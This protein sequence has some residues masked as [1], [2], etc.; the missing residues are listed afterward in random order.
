[1]QIQTDAA[2]AMPLVRRASVIRRVSWRI[3]PWMNW[4][5]PVGFCLVTLMTGRGVLPLLVIFGSPVLILAAGLLGS[6]PRLMLRR[7]GLA[8]ATPGAIVWLLILQWWSW[9]GMAVAMPDDTFVSARPSPLQ[10][11][12]GQGLSDD[13]SM[14][15]FAGSIVVGA[16]SWVAVLILSS[17]VPEPRRLRGWDRVAWS[18][19][20]AGPALLM[21]AGSIGV[22]AVEVQTDAAGERPGQ[23]RQL[24]AAEQVD[25]A[26]ERYDA[27]QQIVSELR[28][29]AAAGRWEANAARAE[30]MN[31][32]GR[33]WESYRLLIDFSHDATP[34]LVVDRD[35]FA[36]VLTSAGWSVTRAD[37]VPLRIDARDAQGAR[38]TMEQQGD[39]PLRIM[40][41]TESWW[42]SADVPVTA[43]LGR[44]GDIGGGYAAE[45]WPR[46]R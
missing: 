37:A 39:T 22:G 9:V 7:Q 11:L 23:V 44:G 43:E 12:T 18:A 25:R 4:L 29:I 33:G 26:Q 6:L 19:A 21:L 1:M 45:E 46:L 38:L 20:A 3:W 13:F 15:V 17:R 31:V 24:S 36:T 5:L 35:A 40:V 10:R 14:G 42:Q 30:S 8:A 32:D 2:T 34:D 27:A 28:G 16:A 41:T